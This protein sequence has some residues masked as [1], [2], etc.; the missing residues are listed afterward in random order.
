M[1]CEVV[2]RD[3]GMG[4]EL[5]P[6]RLQLWDTERGWWEAGLC[7][8]VAWSLPWAVLS[9]SCTSPP[10]PLY[11]AQGNRTLTRPAPLTPS[12]LTLGAVGSGQPTRHGGS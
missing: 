2:D 9:G 1:G 7:G 10:P 5:Q 11:L 3:L 8:R 4:W 12:G 6:G